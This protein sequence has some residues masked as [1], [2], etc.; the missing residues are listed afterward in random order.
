[1]WFRL[2]YCKS[3]GSKQTK[4]RS[5]RRRDTKIYNSFLQVWL[6]HWLA[7]FKLPYLY[8]ILYLC[9]RKILDYRS[10]EMVDLYTEQKLTTK[11]DIWVSYNFQYSAAIFGKTIL[12]SLSYIQK[13]GDVL[14][15]FR[16]LV[17]YYINWR[18]SR[19]LLASL[20]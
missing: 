20:H 7:S 8:G 10:P 12:A 6:S 17:V 11:L 19:F 2:S 16:H 1:M 9:H 14:L 4:C 18:S 3:I 13:T 5:H 15:S